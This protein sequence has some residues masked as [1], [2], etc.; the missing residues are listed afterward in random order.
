MSSLTEERA[1]YEEL[2]LAVIEGDEGKLGNAVET[3]SAE[4]LPIAEPTF[5]PR[6]RGSERVSR[7]A[8]Q[9]YLERVDDSL[10]PAKARRAVQEIL[11]AGRS[12]S[13]PRRWTQHVRATPGLRFVYWH[14]RP[15]IC[16]L[17]LDGTVVT[18]LTRARSRD[19]LRD[20]TDLAEV[21]PLRQRA[22]PASPA[23][24]PLGTAA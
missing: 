18:V 13:T 23:S 7:H 15:D 14:E 17:V 9:R 4:R 6:L 11:R 21:L 5:R 10:S 12:R 2:E 22:L 3:I 20:G 1:L 24:A 16:L 19:A 8:I